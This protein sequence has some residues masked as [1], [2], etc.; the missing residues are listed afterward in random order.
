MSE[1]QGWDLIVAGIFTGFALLF[2]F[3]Y[4]AKVV[5]QKEGDKP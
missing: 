3:G 2:L 4:A 5:A 1:I